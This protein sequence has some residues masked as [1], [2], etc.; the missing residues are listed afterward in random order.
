[1]PVQLTRSR[2]IAGAHGDKKGS[3]GIRSAVGGAGGGKLVTTLVLVAIP[4]S[5]VKGAHRAIYTVWSSDGSDQLYAS[6]FKLTKVGLYCFTAKNPS[7]HN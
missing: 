4:G 3:R 2:F 6:L 1:M 7:L 5:S